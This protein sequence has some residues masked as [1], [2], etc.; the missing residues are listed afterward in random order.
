RRRTP[1]QRP[2]PRH[3]DAVDLVHQRAALPDGLRGLP[4]DVA[5]VSFPGAPGVVLGHNARIAWGATNIDP[6]VQD[7]VLET[8][9]PANPAA[10]L[11]DGASTPFEIRHAQIQVGG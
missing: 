3:L 11:H 10:Y 2:A 1:C 4:Y 9:D 5:G 7:L 6:D 8:I